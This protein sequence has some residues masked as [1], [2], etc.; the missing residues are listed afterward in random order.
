MN[1]TPEQIPDEVVEAALKASRAVDVV[2]TGALAKAPDEQ[3]IRAA[4]AA[5]LPVLLGEPV[6]WMRRNITYK[7]TDGR[8]DGE[9]ILSER[10]VFCDDI[11][12]YTLPTPE[13]FNE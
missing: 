2:R 6:G 1:I 8:R 7:D 9:R 5:A 4:L 12:L 10:K 3:R 13:Q 11:P